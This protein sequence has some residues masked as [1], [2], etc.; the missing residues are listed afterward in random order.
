MKRHTIKAVKSIKATNINQ[1]IR[2]TITDTTR[3][4][5]KRQQSLVK[6]TKYE[7]FYIPENFEPTDK[8]I[9]RFLKK[10]RKAIEAFAEQK[11][12]ELKSATPLKEGYFKQLPKLIKKQGFK[13][14]IE[15]NLK[16][17]KTSTAYDVYSRLVDSGYI[18]DLKALA[19]EE[20]DPSKIAYVKDLYYVY[21]TTDGRK[22][23]LVESFRDPKTG[24]SGY[25]VEMTE[26]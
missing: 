13:K 5:T 20:I 6:Y 25:Y 22:I 4:Q 9:Q 8:N 7:G 3:R 12:K 17:I 18:E 2:R 1:S 24:N 19:N 21:T 16:P 11:Q 15:K 10:N 26:I 14:A 23:L